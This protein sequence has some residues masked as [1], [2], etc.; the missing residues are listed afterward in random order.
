M[1]F[2]KLKKK[3]I[4]YSVTYEINKLAEHLI[5][6]CALYFRC[7]SKKENKGCFRKTKFGHYLLMYGSAYFGWLEPFVLLYLQEKLHLII[8]HL[9]ITI[10]KNNLWLLFSHND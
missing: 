7:I 4:S 3:Y 6:N 1:I 5:K 8:H 9:L 2:S 10:L